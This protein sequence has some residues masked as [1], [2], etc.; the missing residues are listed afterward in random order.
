[1]LLMKKTAKLGKIR[2]VKSI[3]TFKKIVQGRVAYVHIEGSLVPRLST[4]MQ[5]GSD[6]IALKDDNVSVRVLKLPS[7]NVTFV[8]EI[9]LCNSLPVALQKYLEV[10]DCEHSLYFFF[11]RFFAKIVAPSGSIDSYHF[12]VILSSRQNLLT[13]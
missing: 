1:M 4:A 5:E 13:K 8:T 11:F 7:K 6:E 3:Y 9:K 2:T 12:R 10:L